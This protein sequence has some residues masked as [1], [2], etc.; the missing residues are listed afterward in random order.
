[1]KRLLQNRYLNYWVVLFIDL[2]IAALSMV[3]SVMAVRYFGG[4]GAVDSEDAIY[5][6]VVG[7]PITVL[8]FYLFRTY[9]HVIRHSSLKG[10]W[11]I[12]AAVSLKAIIF[13]VLLHLVPSITMVERAIV[14]GVLL[15]FMV[16]LFGMT[17]VRVAMIIIYDW[18]VAHSKDH[19][20]RVLVY[21]T[22]E[23]SVALTVRLFKSSHYRIIGF[24][25]YGKKMSQYKL[26]EHKVYYFRSED[27]FEKVFGL[28]AQVCYRPKDS[29]YGKCTVG[30]LDEYT[31][32][33][34]N[35]KMEKEGI[36][37][38]YND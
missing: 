6:F 18:I 12:G 5:M 9:R 35:E 7:M 27:E 20:K 23:K 22:T 30:D 11:S 36:L 4:G 17:A 21:G 3:A 15:D 8:C 14:M 13:Y 10:L 25:T 24:L 33:A 34:F 1:M 2:F 28:Y 19:R 26:S 29:E 32:S 16:C 37:Y 38:N 31:L